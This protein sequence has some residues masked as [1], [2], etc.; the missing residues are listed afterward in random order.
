[1]ND[2]EEKLYWDSYTKFSNSVNGIFSTISQWI[3]QAD[4]ED[5]ITIAEHHDAY[6]DILHREIRETFDNVWTY[7]SAP[8]FIKIVKKPEDEILKLKSDNKFVKDTAMKILGFTKVFRA[9]VASKK[10]I[11]GH[12]CLTDFMFLFDKCYKALPKDLKTFKCEL[13]ELFP[14]IFDTK[15]VKFY[16]SFL[17]NYI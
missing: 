2:E 8:G 1:M 15:Q 3:I 10:P 16:I 14:I 5:S 13:H 7:E 17:L 12:N 4:D 6:G 9:M 11:I